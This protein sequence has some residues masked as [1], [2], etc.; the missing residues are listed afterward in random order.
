MVWN[1]FQTAICVQNVGVHVSCSSHVCTQLAAFFID[2]RAEWSTTRGWFLSFFIFV[3]TFYSL[4]RVLSSIS[5]K[6]S[7]FVTREHYF[8][9]FLKTSQKIFF[10]KILRASTTLVLTRYTSHNNTFL[11]W[12]KVFYSGGQ[13][14]PCFLK[15]HIFRK[16][17]Y[18]K[19]I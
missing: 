5:Y 9:H 6:E 18:L 7:F 2:P 14:L 16:L 11:T 15:W 13:K 12:C 3:L 1:L 8:V 19:Y 10:S 17:F 4:A